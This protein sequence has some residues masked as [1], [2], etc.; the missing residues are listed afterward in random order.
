MRIAIK[1]NNNYIHTV[2]RTNGSK[3]RIEPNKFIVIDTD[4]D[5]EIRYWTSL[6]P[7]NVEKIGISV[8]VNE[9]DIQRLEAGEYTN[10][11]GRIYTD[12]SSIGNSVSPIA[13][14]IAQD[15]E[16][17]T[18][19][20]ETTISEKKESIPE[21]YFYSKEELLQMDKEDLMNICNNFNIKYKR[22]NSVKTL[23]NLIL[24]SGVL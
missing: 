5:Y 10:F 6:K 22:N 1:N 9:T 24:E 11:N 13:K 4:S 17:I 12:V 3:M 16:P 20:V 14:E 18:E 2:C 21:N 15:V 23:V 7:E 8:F 19:N